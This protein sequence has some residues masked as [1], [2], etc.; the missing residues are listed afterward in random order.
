MSI[1]SKVY[2]TMAGLLMSGVWAN[3]TIT[4]ADILSGHHAEERFARAA[5]TSAGQE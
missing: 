5:A 2:F 1:S 3:N 4:P